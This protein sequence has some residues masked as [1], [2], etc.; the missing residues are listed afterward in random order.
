MEDSTKN[1]FSSLMDDDPNAFKNAFDVAIKTKL[2]DKFSETTKEVSSSMIAPTENDSN[3]SVEEAYGRSGANSYIFKTPMDAKKFQKAALNA[4]ANKRI[5]NVKGKEVSIGD[6][7]DSDVEEMLYFIAKDMKAE[8]KENV[9]DSS[10]IKTLQNIILSEEPIRFKLNDG[11][12]VKITLPEAKTLVKAHDNLNISNQQTMRNS[13]IES[14][15]EFDKIM[16]FSNK[17]Q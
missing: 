1:M 4:G 10:I 15:N 13:L 16:N 8:I 9:D 2:A 7:A 6:I 12:D 11:S 14:K 5:V 17:I 3:D